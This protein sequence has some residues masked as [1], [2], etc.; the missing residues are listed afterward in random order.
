[1]RVRGMILRDIGLIAIG[2]MAAKACKI[3]RNMMRVS[4][5]FMSEKMVHSCTIGGSWIT[6]NEC[7]DNGFS[8]LTKKD[9]VESALAILGTMP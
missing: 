2:L 6:Y 3:C 4:M 5:I 8:R 9:V 7:D 1:M